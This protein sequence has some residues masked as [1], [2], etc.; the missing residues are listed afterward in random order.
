MGIYESSERVGFLLLDLL[1]FALGSVT[2]HS[3]K[4][5][6]GP[7]WLDSWLRYSLSLQT[8]DHYCVRSVLPTQLPRTRQ[9]SLIQS[10]FF[11]LYCQTPN[12]S[13]IT[14][15]FIWRFYNRVC[16]HRLNWFAGLVIIVVVFYGRRAIASPCLDGLFVPTIA[17]PQWRQLLEGRWHGHGL[18][19]NAKFGQGAWGKVIVA[20]KWQLYDFGTKCWVSLLLRCAR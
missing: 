15:R 8:C 7:K 14:S 5:Q 3:N 2:T 12:H 6:N 10:V 17:S 20:R 16:S 4:V 11:I 9:E 19:E 18:P 13:Y 1:V